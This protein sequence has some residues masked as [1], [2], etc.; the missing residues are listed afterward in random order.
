MTGLKD[1]AGLGELDDVGLGD[2]GSLRVEM[3]PAPTYMIY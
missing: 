1:L 2:R 3:L